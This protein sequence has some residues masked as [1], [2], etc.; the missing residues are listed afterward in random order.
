MDGLFDIVECLNCQN[1]PEYF[2]L[3]DRG[4][5]GYVIENCRF[6]SVV[7]ARW[8]AC[9]HMRTFS[10]CVRDVAGHARELPWTCYEAEARFLSERIANFKF[11]NFLPQCS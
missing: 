8:A 7:S 2:F 5:L 10:H 11:G 6:Y 3:H 9:Y 4:R 1:R